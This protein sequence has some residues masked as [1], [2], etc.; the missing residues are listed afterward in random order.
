MRPMRVRMRLAAASLPSECCADALARRRAW[1]FMQ[2][3]VAS[4][5]QDPAVNRLDAPRHACC[6]RCWLAAAAQ[7]C[8]CAAAATAG[9][10]AL[11][12]AGR[13]AERA[14]RRR[15]SARR[16][17][18]PPSMPAIK[19]AGED[20][21]LGRV[22]AAQ[23]R[24]RRGRLREDR[25]RLRS[26]AQRR[27]LPG[28]QSGRALRRLLRRHARAGDRAR[29][30][31]RRAALP[32]R[33]ARSARSSSTCSTAPSSWSS[34]RSPAS[35]RPPPA[36]STRAA[37]GVPIRARCRRAPR[38]SR[39]A[40]GVAERAVREGYRVLTAKADAVEQRAI[41]REQAGFSAEREQ[42]CRD[43]PARGPVRLLRRPPH[44]GPGRL[45]PGPARHHHRAQA[46]RQAEAAPGRA[47]CR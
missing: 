33:G 1:H 17:R 7:A 8:R 32:A 38:R 23:W 21:I 35:S 22:A 31:G 30:A 4:R 16:R 34:R 44:R 15:G 47:R 26:E 42:I 41:A 27:G 20:A 14:S 13:P 24:L 40:R 37:C 6:R 45:D 2:G 9:R 43:L 29:P 3:A 28:E 36:A 39:A 46:R 11:Q 19:V 25:D 18:A 12:P 10:A 5:P